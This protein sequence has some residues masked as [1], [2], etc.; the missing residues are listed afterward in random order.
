MIDDLDLHLDYV[1]GFIYALDTSVA[2]LDSVRAV[3]TTKSYLRPQ[4][5]TYGLITLDSTLHVYLLFND[6]ENDEYVDW[7]NTVNQLGLVEELFA[8]GLGKWGVL[9]VPEGEEYFWVNELRKQVIIEFAQLN[10]Y[11]QLN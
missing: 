2:S 4:G 9:I 1:D 11:L 3:L 10:H 8:F 7:Y 6:L 5:G